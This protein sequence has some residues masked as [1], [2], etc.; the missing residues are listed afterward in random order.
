[1]SQYFGNE[2]TVEFRAYVAIAL[3]FYFIICGIAV[4]LGQIFGFFLP[5]RHKRH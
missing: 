3:F 2:R 4:I 5:N 1:M